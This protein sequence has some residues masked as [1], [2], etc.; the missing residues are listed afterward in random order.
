MKNIQFSPWMIEESYKYYRSAEI[1]KNEGNL[2]CVAEINAA[3]SIEIALKS[4]LVT[5]AKFEGT[6]YE[7]YVYKKPRGAPNGHNLCCL[8]EQLPEQVKVAIFTEELKNWVAR[9]S[10]TFTNSRYR[11]EPSSVKS[12]GSVIIEVA[13]ELLQNIVRFYGANNIELVQSLK[14]LA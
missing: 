4:F 5:V 1:L 8:Y 6:P 10:E 14:K 3:L 13:F 9:F 12:S 11:Y 7:E 2:L